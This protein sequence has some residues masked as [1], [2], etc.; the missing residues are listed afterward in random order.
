MQ[1]FVFNLIQHMNAITSSCS[2]N[3]CDST[4]TNEIAQS[5]QCSPI[6]KNNQYTKNSGILQKVIAKKQTTW[7]TLPSY[8]IAL[9][10]EIIQCHNWSSGIENYLLSVC[11]NI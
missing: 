5:Y 2:L 11:M 7:L 1:T 6:L 10:G 9:H 4:V 3:I 8:M